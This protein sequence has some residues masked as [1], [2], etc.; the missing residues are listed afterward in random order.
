[1]ERICRV[2]NQSKKT[3]YRDICRNCYQIQWLKSNPEKVCS[4][5]E[6]SFK[7][8]GK[9]CWTC[10][11][12]LRKQKTRSIPCSN[13]QRVGLLILNKTDQLCT[14]CDRRKKEA[15]DPSL[16]QRRRE[17]T[18]KSNRKMR[19]TDVNAPIRR[20]KGWWKTVQGYVMIFRPNHANARG[21][22]CLNEHTFVMSESL[23]RPLTKDET[24]HHINGVRDDN[25]IENLELWS[26]SHPP[27]QRVKDKVK[28]AKEIL[29][30]YCDL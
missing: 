28:W 17:Q 4:A 24:V 3:P 15:A 26:N 2:C 27:G 11:A 6:K 22:G 7:T 10:L 13:C 14:L 30:K 25:R 29:M 5:C 19:G 23:G 18:R 12:N 8:P 16:I 9:Q 21:T 1:M 20:S